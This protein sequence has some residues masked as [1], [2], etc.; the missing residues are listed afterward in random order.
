MVW[1]STDGPLKVMT[2]MMVES[3]AFKQVRIIACSSKELSMPSS[4]F[5]HIHLIV[6]ISLAYAVNH[7]VEEVI[8]VA[9]RQFSHLHATG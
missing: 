3:D 2:M 6:F 7:I 5:V 4:V 1:L 8:A 9:L